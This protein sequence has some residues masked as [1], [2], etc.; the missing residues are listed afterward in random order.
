MPQSILEIVFKTVKQG[1][2]GKQA[3]AELKELKGTVGEVTDG[4]L[5]F[6]LASLTMAGSVVAV[7]AAVQQSIANWQAYGEQIRGLV[8]VTGMGS[9]EASRLAQTFDDFGIG[10]EQTS[11]ILETAARKGFIANI[12]AVAKLADQYVA[13]GDQKARDKLMTDTLG[14][15]GLELNKVMAQGGDAIRAQAKAQADGLLIKEDDARAI[16]D[17][18]KAYDG[19]NDS[20][21]A[22]RNT[23]A[24]SL[25]PSLTATIN[26]LAVNYQMLQEGKAIWDVEIFNQK[27]YAMSADEASAAL[28]R[29]LN[30]EQQAVD[31]GFIHAQVL[32]TNTAELQKQAAAANT[33]AM[34]MS[35]TRMA[36]L[37]YN[38]ALEETKQ[39]T[40]ALRVPVQNLEEAIKSLDQAKQAFSSGLA[41]KI[42]SELR[43]AGLS[44]DKLNQ[45]LAAVDQQF[46]TQTLRNQQM[47]DWITNL[48]AR[49]QQ[50]VGIGDFASVLAQMQSAFQGS[51]PGVQAALGNLQSAGTSVGITI[52]NITIND[53]MTYQ[54]FLARLKVDLPSLFQR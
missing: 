9:E 33:A 31:T 18:R 49:Y 26:Q 16:E 28:S 10:V 42:E 22:A 29:Y 32:S 37:A 13:L 15:T 23:I 19:W 45:A 51:D 54:E 35:A 36:Q 41:G 34:G 2:G 25:L 6:N 14:K 17:L 52:G 30:W 38:Q 27:L 1:Q 7:G 40:E 11:A 53:E 48:V 4:L 8:S 44:G 50:G 12:D 43:G 24:K 5:G 20:M 46:G 3:A 39:K 21:D 47:D